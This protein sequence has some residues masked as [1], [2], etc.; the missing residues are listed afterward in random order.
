MPG[1]IEQ[2]IAGYASG[3]AIM[4]SGTDYLRGFDP[5]AVFGWLDNHCGANPL[6]PLSDA[7]MDLAHERGVRPNG[8]Q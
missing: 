7:V 8:G 5:E 2:W 6:E 4:Q 3:I 1:Q